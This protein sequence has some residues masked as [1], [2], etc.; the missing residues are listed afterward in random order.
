MTKQEAIKAL[1]QA[2]CHEEVQD[3]INQAVNSNRQPSGAPVRWASHLRNAEWY[4]PF[5]DQW[6]ERLQIAILII[7]AYIKNPKNS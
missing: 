6:Q 1:E 4:F 3:I 2:G 7:E 5:K